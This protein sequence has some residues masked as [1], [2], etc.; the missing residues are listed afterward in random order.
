MTTNIL[1]LEMLVA[2]NESNNN[3]FAVRF[4]PAFNVDSHLV[5]R[6]MQCAKCNFTTAKILCAMSWGRFQIMGSQLVQ[7]G[8]DVSPYHFVWDDVMQSDYFHRYML[9]DHL[10][11]TLADVL[12]DPT[13]RAL[14]A[15]LY[16]GPGNIEGYSERLMQT[17]KAHGLTVTA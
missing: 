5:Y 13:K 15:R 7:L 17:A 16:N 3:P 6:M 12:N 14:F 11:L 9:A 1:N 4:E 10:T 8:L 2:W